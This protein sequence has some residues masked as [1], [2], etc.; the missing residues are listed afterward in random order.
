MTI[1]VLLVDDQPLMVFGLRMII[2]DAPDLECAGS[3]GNGREAVRLARESR[4]DV[5]VMDVRMPEL[6]G[7]RATRLIAA[8]PAAPRVLVL[9]T[10]DEDEYIYGALRA[11]ASGFLVKSMALE[12]ILGAIRVVAGGDALI[13]PR[14]PNGS[15]APSS[16]SRFPP[17]PDRPG[18]STVSPSA[19]GRC[20]PLSGAG[21]GC[22]AVHRC[23]WG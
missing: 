1:R 10:F 20:W 23:H 22:A 6:D 18:P 17:P 12:D 15:S 16:R 19:S 5:V 13:A 11:G 21:C 7:I 14:S 3:A 9:T 8:E 4:P 2:D